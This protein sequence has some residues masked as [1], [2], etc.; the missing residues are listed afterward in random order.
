LLNIDVQKIQPHQIPLE[1]P[2]GEG[3]LIA[4][5]NY[6]GH[7]HCVRFCER[8]GENGLRVMNPSP[9]P[10]KFPVWNIHDWS[11]DFFKIRLRKFPQRRKRKKH[12]KR[13]KA[14]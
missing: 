5:W 6:K 9:D 14:R 10:D 4:A 8:M 7:Q 13:T 2:R 12:N 3:V 11:C 1:L